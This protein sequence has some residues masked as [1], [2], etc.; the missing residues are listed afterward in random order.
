MNISIK[1]FLP[2]TVLLTLLLGGC[3]T[4]TWIVS[5]EEYQEERKK[6]MDV[7]HG[8]IAGT[9]DREKGIHCKTYVPVTEIYTKGDMECRDFC[10]TKSSGGG[11][12]SSRLWSICLAEGGRI[13][14]RFDLSQSGGRYRSSFQVCGRYRDPYNRRSYRSRR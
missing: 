1:Y 10:L 2:L 9:C 14:E 4:A 7:F 6:F 13:M 8:K 3:A 11:Q 12:G 5:A